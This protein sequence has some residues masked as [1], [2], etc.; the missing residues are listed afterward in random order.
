MELN[1]RMNKEFVIEEVNIGT[2]KTFKKIFD[3][4]Y[5]PLVR[6]AYSYIKDSHMSEDIVQDV[7]TKIWTKRKEMSSYDNIKTYLY[8][9]VRN[10]CLN[11][12]EHSK[13]KEKYIYH[14]QNNSSVYV[15]TED[16]EMEQEVYKLLFDAIEELPNKCR[17]VFKLHLE[18]KNNNEIAE[19]LEISK[20]TA[21]THKQKA[22]RMITEK[23]GNLSF[24][25]FL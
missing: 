14:V 10:K 9:S 11:E 4:F 3:K 22:K 15:D 20:L 13:V 18:G 19:I 6:F 7:F 24:Y 8:T 25:V 2:R 1:E 16:V 12:L 21:K 5:I 23:L 17:K